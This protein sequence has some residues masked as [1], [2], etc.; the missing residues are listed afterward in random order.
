M[1]SIRTKILLG[2][3]V[4]MIGAVVIGLISYS[5]DR[6]AHYEKERRVEAACEQMMSDA[7]SGDERRLTAAICN[8]LMAK[9]QAERYSGTTRSKKDKSS[10]L[11]RE[12]G[13]N[14]VI[15]EPFTVNLVQEGHMQY[16]QAQFQL[17]VEDPEQV[18]ILHRNMSSVRNRVLLLLTEKKASEIAS[19]EGQRLL[20]RAIVDKIN[21]P[22]NGETDQP[23]VTDLVFTKF[24]I[25]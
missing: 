13:P 4:G 18:E 12:G 5:P 2:I 16:L 24:K 10:A 21:E 17:K 20:A 14:G 7:A 15:V 3:I 9:A 8:E 23:H 25:E 1:M 6:A 19:T 11:N 22:F